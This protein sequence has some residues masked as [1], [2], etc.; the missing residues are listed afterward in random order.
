[1]FK[2]SLSIYEWN[3]SNKRFITI[4]KKMERGEE[5]F[6]T[7]K[8]EMPRLHDKKH[9]WHWTLNW[10]SFVYITLSDTKNV[11][12]T[13]KD[14]YANTDTLFF[15]SPFSQIH[16][17]FKLDTFGCPYSPQKDSFL[18][19][20]VCESERERTIQNWYHPKASMK[21][22][23]KQTKKY[24]QKIKQLTLDHDRTVQHF[25][26]GTAQVFALLCLFVSFTRTHLISL[27]RERERES[28]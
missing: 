20:S 17:R 6:E 14:P 13:N 22:I 15:S 24:N 28:E 8:Q 10:L 16:L 18:S 4:W 3:F 26:A 11:R 2:L 7:N 27:H 21:V 1:M 9:A 12:F 5:S 25:S 23:S 19:V